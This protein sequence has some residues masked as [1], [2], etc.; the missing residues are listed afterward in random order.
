M[1]NETY[2]KIIIECTMCKT[3]F[4]IWISTMNYSLEVEESIRNHF[5]HY[6][7]VCKVLRELEEKK[8]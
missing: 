6:C 1:D 4:E 3:K 5:E 2:K 8:K 7:P